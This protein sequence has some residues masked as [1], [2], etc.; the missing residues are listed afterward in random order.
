M[1]Y[2]YI[3]ISRY[4]DF[5]DLRFWYIEILREREVKKKI[6][7]HIQRKEEREGEGGR[8]KEGESDDE[9]FI[10]LIDPRP[11]FIYSIYASPPGR[12]TSPH[13]C[14]LLLLLLTVLNQ[15]LKICKM[16]RMLTVYDQTISRCISSLTFLC[17]FFQTLDI[18]TISS[19]VS[20]KSYFDSAQRVH[21]STKFCS[22]GYVTPLKKQKKKKHFEIRGILSSSYWN[23]YQIFHL[24]FFQ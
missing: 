10:F 5:W 17:Y 21:T 15:H 12:I 24:K 3:E 7:T 23:I 22:L 19:R 4:W 8:A 6:V 1:R 2:W 16:S 11:P 18:T 9:R 13:S 14:H 20:N